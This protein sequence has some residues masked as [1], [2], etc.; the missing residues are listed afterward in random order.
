MAS[1]TE[2]MGGLSAERGR[3]VEDLMRWV[4]GTNAGGVWKIQTPR[5]FLSS[6]QE[7]ATY[8]FLS[9]FGFLTFFLSRLLPL[10]MAGL[11]CEGTDFRYCRAAISC[12]ITTHVCHDSGE[13][14]ECRAK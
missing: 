3:V 6:N 5:R 13:V 11:L 7:E 4:R 1:M 12:E 9:F 2:F 8:F 14:A 10:P